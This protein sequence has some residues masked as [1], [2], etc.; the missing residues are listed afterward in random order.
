MLE[1]S[2]MISIRHCVIGLR[3]HINFLPSYHCL[4]AQGIQ[5]DKSIVPDQ[6]FRNKLLITAYLKL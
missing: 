4:H 3:C 5:H 6:N 2:F 1:Y